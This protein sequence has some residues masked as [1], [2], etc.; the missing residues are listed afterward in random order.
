MFCFSLFS[1]YAI[2]TKITKE[3]AVEFSIQNN[4]IIIPNHADFNAEHII[5]CGQVFRYQKTDFGYNVYSLHHKASLYCQKDTTIIVCD[6]VNYFI[7]YFDLHTKYDTIKLQLQNDELLISALNYGYG[8]RILRQDLLEVI[9]GFIVSANNNITR[10]RN[11]MENISRH[12]GTNMG[13]YY[14]FPTLNQL[15]TI[16][17]DFFV[18]IKAGYRA[19]YL[20]QVIQQLANGFDLEIVRQLPTEQALKHLQKLSGVGPKVADCILLYGYHITNSFPTDTW[21]KKVYYDFQPQKANQE[22][23]AQTMRNFFVN[24][25]GELSGYAQQYL[26]YHKR[27]SKN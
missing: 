25:Y 18:S 11:I 21:I 1:F 8:I 26:F 17:Q 13:D 5:E 10:I 23:P 15:T 27:G 3:T 2:I 7:N 12:Y 19:P 6:D 22:V 4:Q 24:K 20:W 9:I 14:A 16:P